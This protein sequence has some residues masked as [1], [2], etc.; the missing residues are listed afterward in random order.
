[1]CGEL[2]T[3]VGPDRVLIFQEGNLFPWKTVLDNVA[4]GLKAQGISL[5]DSHAIAR[6]YIKLVHLTGFETRFPYQLSWGMRQRVAVARAL[7]LKPA[8]ILMDEPLASLDAQLRARLQ[9]ELLALFALE[10]QTCLMVTHDLDEAIYMAD[11][12][13][14]LSQRPTRVR[15]I[16]PV[17][18]PRPREVSMRFTF[19]FQRL[20]IELL[21]LLDPPDS[22]NR[23]EEV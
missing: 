6:R 16:I 3:S 20:R 7:V 11:R 22:D 8:C 1:V 13:V 9:D 21:A 19:E 4:F 18:L 12:V 14:I 2:V 17:E 10:C 15:A 23:L 5:D